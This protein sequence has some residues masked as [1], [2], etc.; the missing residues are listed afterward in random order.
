VWVLGNP[1]L[2][3]HQQVLQVVVAVERPVISLEAGR[4]NQRL[5]Q[6]MKPVQLMMS[7]LKMKPVRRPSNVDA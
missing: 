4:F 6:E 7:L 3:I 1:V 5:L 2:Q